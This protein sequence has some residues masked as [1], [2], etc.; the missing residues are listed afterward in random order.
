MYASKNISRAAKYINFNKLTGHSEI[1][2]LLTILCKI[3][4]CI[5][6][7][8]L[9]D[10]KDQIKIILKCITLNKTRLPTKF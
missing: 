5:G 1:Y 3:E 4:P 8:N 9:S 6:L 7:R 10:G 2:T